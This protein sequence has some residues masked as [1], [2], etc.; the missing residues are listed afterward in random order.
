[1][2][3]S[4]YTKQLTDK[5]RMLAKS[6]LKE[7]ESLS[8]TERC[9]IS[10]KEHELSILTLSRATGI[11]QILN[12]QTIHFDDLKSLALILR[13]LA[14]KN[15]LSQTPIYWML[16]LEDY[17]INLIESLPVP[18]DEIQ[19]AL[20]W[21]IRSLINY[22]IDEAVLEYFQ[23][24]AKKSTQNTPFI[25]AVTAKKAL[26]Q[27]VISLLKDVGL[28]LVTIDI[29]ELAMLN[30]AAIYETDEKCTA[31]VYFFKNIAILNISSQKILY[32]TRRINIPS[33]TDGVM[34]YEKLSLEILRYFDFFR[35]Q[36]RL[37]S[38]TRI[39][40][41]TESGD[42]NLIAK[43]LSER[44]LNTVSPYTLSEPTLSDSLKSEVESKYLLNYGC[45]L[46]KDDANATA[47]N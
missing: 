7:E 18:A 19:T 39:F 45:L 32:F 15:D 17:Q 33:S 3:L 10:F 6:Y 29:P 20:S 25:G 46:R 43:A 8:A 4:T 23:L 40:A 24:P 11:N 28:H 27:P 13:G 47:R 16:D 9:C 34:D 41:S 36:W 26:L 14:E 22:P 30:L 38:P 1:M 42:I 35:S 21:R 31:F 44:L 37:S 12:H 5:L 2:D